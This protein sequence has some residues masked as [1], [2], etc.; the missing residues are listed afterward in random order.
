[1][2]DFSFSERQAAAADLAREVYSDHAKSE[3]IAVAEASADPLNRALWEALTGSGLLGIWIAEEAGGAGGGILELCAALEVQGQHVVHAPV[4]SAAV[5]GMFIDRFAPAELR[6]KL[7]PRVV[8]GSAIIAPALA[9][10]GPDLPTSPQAIASVT[11][12]EATVTG[13]KISV[14]GGG[15]AT[16]FLV[17]VRLSSGTTGVALLERDAPRLTVMPVR[18]TDHDHAAHVE[19]AV[20]PA[21][22]VGD[23]SSA[24][25]LYQHCV[26]AACAVQAGVLKAATRAAAEYTSSRTQFGRPLTYFQTVLKRG[27]DAYIDTRAVR[28]TMWHAAWQLAKDADAAESVA[29]AKWWASEAGHRA[30]HSM[31]YLHGGLGN[32][33]TYPVHRY[34]LWAK[35]IDASLG[36]SSQQLERIGAELAR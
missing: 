1:M 29:M 26:V 16:H 35:Q 21:V 15:A 4:L 19:M 33:L 18:T 3:Q 27:A 12:D 20:A 2:I 22:L 7:L 5:G 13:R 9:E 24:E 8:D 6:R 32:D 23:G 30:A 31:L 11:G 34:Y 25:W 14:P 10:P 17:P 36:G 28:L